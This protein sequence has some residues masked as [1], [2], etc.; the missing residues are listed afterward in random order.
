M[1]KWIWFKNGHVVIINVVKWAQYHIDRHIR[2]TG[3]EPQ[4]AIHTCKLNNIA[5][6]RK[7]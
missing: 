6:T 3:I 4:N 7:L 5:G 2:H 1:Y